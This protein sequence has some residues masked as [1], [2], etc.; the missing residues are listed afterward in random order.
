MCLLK[1]FIQIKAALGWIR[2]LERLKVDISSIKLNFYKDEDTE[3]Q[4]L[5]IENPENFRLHARKLEESIL[6]VITSLVPPEES[7]LST[8]L[9]NSPFEIFESLR[10]IT[11]SGI[12]NLTEE[13]IELLP[14]VILDDAHELKDKQFSE[15]ERWLRDRE[16]KIPRWL[17]T[18]IDAIGTSDLRK[19]I[20]DIENEEQPGTNFERDRTIKLLQ[21]EK[22]DRKQFRSIARDICRR[23]FSVMPAFQMRS[24]NSIDDCLLRR[25][26]SLSGADIKALEEKNSTL[27]SEARFSTESVESLIERIP[28]NLPEDVSKAVLHILLQREKRKTPQ[29]G[30]FDDVYSTPENVA[31]DEYLDEQAEITEGE[32]LNQD[33]LPKKTVKSALVTG[34][35]IQLAHLYDRPF[36]YGFDRLADCSSDNIEQFVSLAGSWV[37]ELETRLLRNKPIKLDPKQ[38]HTI[39]M[40]RAKELM[41]EWD[42]P[43]CESV[44]KLIGFIAGR[45][46]EKTLEP[47]APLGEGANAF[48][49]PQL[50]MDKLDEKAPEL[51]AVIHYGIAYNAIQLKENYSC[52]N[53][54]WCLFQLGG[55]PIVANKLTLSRGGFCEGS[56]RDLQESVIK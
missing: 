53:R 37:D 32:D 25:E 47:N 41:S 26:P 16:I 19:A 14:M 18:R 11:I 22:R 15:V 40:Q 55:I 28:P 42:F 33:E 5:A 30:L 50:E 20:S 34:A 56:I 8:S 52:K 3:V 43:H 1:T 48:G 4:R 39:L 45:C 49:I 46:V 31:D 13:S 21:G 51:V 9:A 23:Y 2:K 38:Q 6:K 7:E 24:I 10:S 44:R 54:A 27:I 17:L 36:Y 35:A 12:P 29:V